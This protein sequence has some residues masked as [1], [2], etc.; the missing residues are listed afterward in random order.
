[1]TTNGLLQVAIYLGLLLACVKPL[2]VYMARVYSGATTFL[3][4]VVGPA[5]R[6]LYRL[7]GI[8]K[9]AEMTWRQYSVA[10]LTFSLLSFVAV[11]AFQRV[12]GWLPLNP[13]S[14]AAVSPDSS[15]N[16]A[17][18]F[19]TNTNWQGYGGET[20][21]SYLTQ[22]LALTVQNFLSAATGMAVLIALIRGFT[23]H[24]T[25]TIGNFWVDL[26]RG[27]LYIL[28]PLSLV[29]SLALV[30]QGVVQTFGRITK[31]HFLSQSLIPT[32]TKSRRRPSQ[33]ARQLRRSP[34]S[35]LARTAAA[36]S[37]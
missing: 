27:T 2:G 23:R 18:S 37:T 30:S 34:S 31:P 8:D 33:S 32:V 17:V 5:E 15:F 10:V 4:R 13:E 19:T 1:M 36:S 14:L 28:V 22:M 29:L 12:Q 24:T 21:M 3:D 20:T 26:V 16:T 6:L 25:E 35:S 9:S 7:C 11:Y